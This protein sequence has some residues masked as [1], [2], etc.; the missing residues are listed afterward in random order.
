MF[1]SG[2]VKISVDLF[3]KIIEFLESLDSIEDFDPDT[4]QLHGYV[5]Y[6]LKHKKASIARQEMLL[7]CF[8]EDCGCLRF[9]KGIDGHSMYGGDIPF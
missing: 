6:A 8:H 1:M 2:K 5:L 4:L 3:N 7:Q 9:G